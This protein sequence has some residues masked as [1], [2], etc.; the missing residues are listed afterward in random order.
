MRG[1]PKRRLQMRID[2]ALFEDV[3]KMARHRKVTIT[4]IVE[5]QLRHAVT[6]H[7]LARR[8]AR[9]ADVEDAEQI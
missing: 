5:E 3:E 4:S 1:D 8:T 2:S 6:L 7:K 9:A